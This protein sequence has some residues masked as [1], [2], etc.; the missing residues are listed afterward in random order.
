MSTSAKFVF[1]MK[2]A[3]E[4]QE[5][6]RAA[7]AENEARMDRERMEWEVKQAKAR[8]TRRLE[9]QAEFDAKV[10]DVLRRHLTISLHSW[11][12]TTKVQLRWDHNVIAEDEV[13]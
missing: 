5:A 2:A 4:Q 12:G 7:D 10:L 3:R 6:M 13:S 1:T 8:E 11:D 9:A